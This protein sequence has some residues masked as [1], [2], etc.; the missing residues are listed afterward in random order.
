LGI[1]LIGFGYSIETPSAFSVSAIALPVFGTC[2]CIGSIA[3]LKG[4]ALICRVLSIP[5]ITW[6]GR[7]SYS[8]YLWHW[9][10]IVM[11]RWTVGIEGPKLVALAC[12][13]T[14]LLAILSY[15]LL[16]SMSRRFQ[17]YVESELTL[18]LANE[19]AQGELRSSSIRIPMAWVVVAFGMAS[20]LTT[21]MLYKRIQHSKRLPQSVV[22]ADTWDNP[23]IVKSP[24]IVPGVLISGE[25]AREWSGRKLFVIGDSHVEAYAE[26][27]SMLRR[28]KGVAIYAI[29]YG[30]LRVGSFVKR[31]TPA[32]REVQARFL[33]TLEDCSSPGDI[34]FLPGLRLQRFCNQDYVIESDELLPEGPGTLLEAERMVAVEEGAGL[35]QAIDQLGLKVLLEA[36]KPIYRTPFFRVADYFNRMNP[37]GREGPSIER[38]ELLRHRANAMKSLEEMVRRFKNTIIWDPF[39]VLCPGDICCGNDGGLPLY[40]D[41]DHLSSY[42]NR[43]L[44]PDFVRKIK[45]IWGDYGGN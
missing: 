25:P 45:E 28:D 27:L 23:W 37:V 38:E 1:L 44:Y 43:K 21:G 10:V 39:P 32:D 31:Q 7:L 40:F 19:V 41:G 11:Q 35:V 18:S 20:L 4:K 17:P 29:G 24:G 33:S 5:L 22:A 36:P 13:L 26:M 16:E 9:P 6:I 14:L 3:H 12:I 42:G 8:L 30:G 34:V 15:Y 2:L